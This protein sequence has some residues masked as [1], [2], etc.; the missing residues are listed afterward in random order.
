[1][2]NAIPEKMVQAW[3][4]LVCPWKLGFQN[5]VVDMDGISTGMAE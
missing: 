2:R 1:M 3:N 4:K 5:I